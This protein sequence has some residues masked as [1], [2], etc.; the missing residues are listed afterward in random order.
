MPVISVEV[1]LGQVRKTAVTE[2]HC[3]LTSNY[4]KKLPDDTTTA[5]FAV[6]LVCW[7]YRRK[8]AQLS[9]QTLTRLTLNGHVQGQL[10]L[11]D[12]KS[13]WDSNCL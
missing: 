10:P 4:L 2:Q 13:T 3:T 11:A 7:V 6:N 8:R 5:S 1:P 12:L 9:A